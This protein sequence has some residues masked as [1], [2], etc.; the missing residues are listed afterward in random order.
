MTLAQQKRQKLYIILSHLFGRLGSGIFSFGI[1]LMILR[2]TGSASNFGFSQIVGPIVSLLLLPVTGSV[3]DRLNHKKIV[4]VAQLGSISGILL[5]LAAD[6]MALLPRLSLIYILLTILAVADLFLE[7][8]YSSSMVTMVAKDDVQQILSIKQIVG[9]VCMIAAP[10]LGAVLYQLLSFEVFVLVEIASEVITLL[11][12]FGIH[13]YMFQA[14]S[15]AEEKEAG[16]P[17]SLPGWRGM[18]RLFKEGID[19]VKAS[20]ALSFLIIFSML[21]NFLIAGLNAGLPFVEIQV[22]QLTNAEYGITEAM[23]AA[24]LLAASVA[25]ARRKE[26]KKPLHLAWRLIMVVFGMLLGMAGLIY[27]RLP[28]TLNFAALIG[29]FSVFGGL[30]GVINIP[31]HL[32]SV[33]NIPAKMQGRVFNLM[34]TSAQL[35]MPLGILLFTFLLDYPVRPDLLFAVLA[36][37]G[38]VLTFFLPKMLKV[39]L[40]EM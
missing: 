5:F 20:P 25:L 12:V 1:G 26:I 16:Q 22:F 36:V 32:W 29:F 24:G 10:V 18:L 40:Q 27:V 4:I 15:Q 30:I 11:L 3:I 2:E 39:S 13:F 17:E 7:T 34:G 21:I 38:M 35:L 9:T 37:A 14:G 6:S 31:L 28:H 19:F 33:K 8:T 23:F